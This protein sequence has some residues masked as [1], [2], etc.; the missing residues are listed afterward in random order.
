M[1]WRA[2]WKSVSST[3]L[4]LEGRSEL[5]P[6]GQNHGSRKL[7]SDVYHCV[8]DDTHQNCRGWGTGFRG[9]RMSLIYEV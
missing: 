1:E 4:V 6:G 3:L 9:K 5:E 8:N 2:G 7:E